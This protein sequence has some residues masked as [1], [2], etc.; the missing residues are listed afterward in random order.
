MFAAGTSPFYHAWPLSHGTFAEF[1]TVP[2]ARLPCDPFCTGGHSRAICF[3]GLWNP[4][5]SVLHNEMYCSIVKLKGFGVCMKLSPR[6]L[7]L[8][9]PLPLEQFSFFGPLS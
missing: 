6:G 9:V 2:N 8:D 3:D 4:R 7:E 1:Q 5:H